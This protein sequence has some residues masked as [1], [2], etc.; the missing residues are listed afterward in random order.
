ML[1]LQMQAGDIS[2]VVA[3]TLLDQVGQPVNLNP[4]VSLTFRMVGVK[5]GWVQINNVDAIKAQ[6]DDDPETFGQ[7]F[8]QWTSTDTARAGLYQCWFLFDGGSGVTHY[9]IGEKLYV[10]IDPSP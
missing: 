7:V 5:D 10:L 3:L 1:S 8:Y 2:P 9:P 6:D 4:F